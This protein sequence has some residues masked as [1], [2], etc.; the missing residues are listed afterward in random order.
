M[1]PYP[2]YPVLIGAVDI[3]LAGALALVAPVLS[4]L[5]A[6]VGA[7]VVGTVLY[8]EFTGVQ[9]PPITR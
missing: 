1:T 3:G 9:V 4:V 7:L 5:M 2:L 8:H 6:C